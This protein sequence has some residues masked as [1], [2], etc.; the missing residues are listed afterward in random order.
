M[1]HH[2][3]LHLT[4]EQARLVVEL[5]GSVCDALRA[6]QRSIEDTSQLDLFEP[7][8]EPSGQNDTIAGENPIP[9]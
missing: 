2:V 6:F 8:P 4:P 1:K 3:P 5:L 9:S 7:E